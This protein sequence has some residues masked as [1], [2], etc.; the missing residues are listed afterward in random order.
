M[1][2]VNTYSSRVPRVMKPEILFQMHNSVLSGHLGCKKTKDK[3]L[4]RFYW[5]ALKDDI[6]LHI[7]ICDICAKDK[8]PVNPPKAPLGSL[9]VGAP[10]DCI[11]T[12]YLDLITLISC[13]RKWKQ[14]HPATHRS[15][16]KVCRNLGSSRYDC[17]SVCFQNSK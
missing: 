9:S 5:Y 7:R 3:T 11:A 8:E 10:G 6:Y 17:R 12:D 1:A 4:Q 15:Y 16:F 2:L 13:N 14:I